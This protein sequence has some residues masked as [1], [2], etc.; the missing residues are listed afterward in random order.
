VR[1]ECQ[2]AAIFETIL[3][4]VE[5]PEGESALEAILKSVELP[6]GESALEAILKPIK[7]SWHEVSIHH[8]T[9]KPRRESWPVHAGVHPRV[10]PGVHA[11]TGML[12]VNLAGGP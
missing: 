5:L 10:H 12:G 6:E 3:K 2:A 9:A 1:Q 8:R 4:S 7:G 11:A